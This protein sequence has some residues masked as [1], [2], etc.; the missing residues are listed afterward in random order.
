[1]RYRHTQSGWVMMGT[2]I[3]VLLLVECLP[4]PAYMP[5]ECLMLVAALPLLVVV[6]LFGTLTVE[7]DDATI[8]LRFGV[9]LIRETFSLADVASC[10]PV[11]NPWWWGWGIRLIPAARPG[12]GR[13][14]LYNVSG[15]D[16][17]E[18]VL[19]N[20]KTFRIGTDEPHV[21]KDFIQAKVNKL[22]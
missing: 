8:R 4:L 20:G 13:G 15:L 16:A 21:L 17:V 2:C 9:G 19:K 6:M 5:R 18:L 11:R 14:W 22:S 12:D 1:M 7:V 10:R 3:A